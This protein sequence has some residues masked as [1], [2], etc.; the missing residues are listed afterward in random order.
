MLLR[1]TSTP[2]TPHRTDNGFTW[3]GGTIPHKIQILT[4]EKFGKEL[5]VVLYYAY[6]RRT[7]DL[8]KGGGKGKKRRTLV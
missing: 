2:K 7:F 3:S 6:D 5:R 1:T 4:T 8:K